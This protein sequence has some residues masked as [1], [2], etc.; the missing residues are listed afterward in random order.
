MAIDDDSINDNDNTTER[1]VN[2]VN[3]VLSLEEWYELETAVNFL[4]IKI[5][6]KKLSV[7]F[8]KTVK[9][10]Q[11]ILGTYLRELETM[12]K[13]DEINDNIDTILDEEEKTIAVVR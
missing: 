9:V 11:K 12:I 1:Q 7:H 8:I 13:L 3:L 5:I 2:D 10:I 4:R 6:E